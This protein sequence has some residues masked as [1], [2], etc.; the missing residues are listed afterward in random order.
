MKKLTAIAI[1]SVFINKECQKN[2]CFQFA[3][4]LTL[5]NFVRNTFTENFEKL[6]NVLYSLFHSKAAGSL[7]EIAKADWKYPK[8]PEELQNMQ[9]N[10]IMSRRISVICCI[11]GFGSVTGQ[12]LVRISQEN[13]LLPS[14][15]EEKRLPMLSSYLPYDY[16]VSP[17][18][19]FTWFI[20][21]F[22]TGLATLVYSG[23]YCLFVGLVLHL[24]GQV[25]NLRLSLKNLE[26]RRTSNKQLDGSLFG[27]R[28]KVIIERH[29]SL[30]QL[31]LV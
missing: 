21:Y 24:R 6:Y 19:E 4:Y 2:R 28:I 23:V 11:L 14:G 22:G 29:E 9:E 8:S 17:L 5:T 13:G 25:S 20:Q 30:N 31:V 10:A 15:S 18:Y 16:K 12:L 27:G 1:G 3:P 7:I 26:S